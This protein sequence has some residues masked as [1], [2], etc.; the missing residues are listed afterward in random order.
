MYTIR[1]AL[2]FFVFG[3]TIYSIGY[4][5]GL[6]LGVSRAEISPIDCSWCFKPSIEESF[7][8]CPRIQPD[9]TYEVSRIAEP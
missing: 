3:V 2:F 7:T 9:G 8:M 4:F 5:E 1:R 6:W